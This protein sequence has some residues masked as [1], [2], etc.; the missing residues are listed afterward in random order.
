MSVLCRFGIHGFEGCTCSRCSAQR[1]DWK[2]RRCQTCGEVRASAGVE[3]VRLKEGRNAL[4]EHDYIVRRPCS[5][6]GA[7]RK[8]TVSSD[9]RGCT[10]ICRCSE[11]GLEKRYE[12]HY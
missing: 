5:C 6:G 3:H 7:W 11:C 10:V 2:G 4:A 9:S 8:G 1:H 12:F